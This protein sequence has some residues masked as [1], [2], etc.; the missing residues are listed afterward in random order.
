MS[1]TATAGVVYSVAGLGGSTLTPVSTGTVT[2]SAP[3]GL[4]LDGAGNLFIADFDNGQLVE[5]PTTT[6]LAPSVV[7]TGGL[8]QHP[9]SVAIDSLGNIYIGDAGPGGLDASSSEPWLYGEN[10]GRGFSF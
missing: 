10:T 8:L 2:L 6:G 7:N 4:A 5:V 9:I 1:P 3:Y